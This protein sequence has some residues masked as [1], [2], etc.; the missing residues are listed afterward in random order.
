MKNVPSSSGLHADFG[1]VGLILLCLHMSFVVVV[2]VAAVVVVVAVVVVAVAVN[3]LP[4][5]FV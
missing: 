5:G 3:G 1:D 2:G 4:D